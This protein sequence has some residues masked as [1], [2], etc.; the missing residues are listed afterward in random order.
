MTNI[1]QTEITYYIIKETQSHLEKLRCRLRDE[2]FKSCQF[3]FEKYDRLKNFGVIPC[4]GQ[5]GIV[6]NGRGTFDP[7]EKGVSRDRDAHHNFGEFVGEDLPVLACNLI[8]Q[9]AP[10]YEMGYILVPQRV[11]MVAREIIQNVNNFVKQFDYNFYDF[12]CGKFFNI[13]FDKEKVNCIK[14]KC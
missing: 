5:V 3:L 11:D 4:E 9:Y 14:Y 7:I 6:I 10:T 13:V 8:K 1:S 12:M 2:Y